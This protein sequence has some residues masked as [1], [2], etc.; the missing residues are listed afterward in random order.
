MARAAARQS[1]KVATTSKTLYYDDPSVIDSETTLSA[2][3]TL[4]PIK[5]SGQIQNNQNDDDLLAPFRQK[6]RSSDRQT[7]HSFKQKWNNENNK[8]IREKFIETEWDDDVNVPVNHKKITEQS[9][10][11]KEKVIKQTKSSPSNDKY[12]DKA[13]R[14][15]FKDTWNDNDEVVRIDFPVTDTKGWSNNNKNNN[16]NDKQ[17]LSPAYALVWDSRNTPKVAS[18]SIINNKVKDNKSWSKST[19]VT[20]TKLTT[21]RPERLS[22]NDETSDYYDSNENDGFSESETPKHKT[23]LKSPDSHVSAKSNQI[24]DHTFEEITTKKPATFGWKMIINHGTPESRH[25]LTTTAFT[26][27]LTTAKPKITTTKLK[28][29]TRTTTTTTTTTTR[30]T[31]KPKVV[32]FE[33]LK[34]P[35]NVLIDKNK[36][37][38]HRIGNWVDSDKLIERRNEDSDN[39]LREQEYDKTD[40][41]NDKVEAAPLRSAERRR[42]TIQ[43]EDYDNNFSGRLEDSIPGSP[44]RDYPTYST[45]P[46][47]GFS[48]KNQEWPGYYADV[49]AGCQVRIFNKILLSLQAKNS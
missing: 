24:N 5:R 41:Y 14:Q 32:K 3:T 30:T 13:I 18:G 2:Q 43:N 44:E 28:P 46:R 35:A 16:Q 38:Q 12:N 22:F 36:Q 4:R 37:K 9:N 8:P 23:T 47:T 42:G 1:N 19:K 10:L 31:T 33:K 11:S 49:E 25:R 20:T 34:S 48:C 29:T 7:R 40:Y 39:Y 26:E 45:I 17:Q 15:S 27:I 21:E 6:G